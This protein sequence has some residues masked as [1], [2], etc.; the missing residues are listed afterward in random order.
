MYLKKKLFSCLNSCC[1]DNFSSFICSILLVE[2]HG[3]DIIKCM[4]RVEKRGKMWGV[5]RRY[6]W[7]HTHV[8]FAHNWVTGPF[9][10]DLHIILFS[11]SSGDASSKSSALLLPSPSAPTNGL[12]DSMQ[13]ISSSFNPH[14]NIECCYKILLDA[15]F[16]LSYINFSI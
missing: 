1:K 3:F 5:M 9:I 8:T 11:F 15:D 2:K 4:I 12:H 14:F 13:R 7:T 6:D 10:L 16:F